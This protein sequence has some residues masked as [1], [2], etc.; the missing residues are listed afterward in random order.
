MKFCSYN[1]FV[2]PAIPL[3]EKITYIWIAAGR[4]VYTSLAIQLL[5]LVAQFR[6][7]ALFEWFEPFWLQVVA[8]TTS[9]YIF[10]LLLYWFV[11]GMWWVYQTMWT[12]ST[13]ILKLVYRFKSELVRLWMNDGAHIAINLTHL[14][15]TDW[16]SRILLFPLVGLYYVILWHKLTL[17]SLVLV[18]L[19]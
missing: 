4:I 5:L 19:S 15:I 7:L 10:L 16:I 2:F 9:D 6:S 11:R 18:Y 12:L 3:V 14:A 13:I 1:L 8:A 17:A